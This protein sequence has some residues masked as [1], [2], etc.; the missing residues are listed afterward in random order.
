MGALKFISDWFVTS[1]MPEN[2]EYAFLADD[3]DFSKGT[4]FANE[5]SIRGEDLDKINFDAILMSD[6]WLGALKSKNAKH[7]KKDWWRINAC[8]V[9]SIK[10]VRLMHAR[11]WEKGRDQIFTDKVEQ[12]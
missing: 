4:F 1:K 9:A 10:M 5:M 6:F 12:F 3:E 8:T 2:F 7:L 11:R